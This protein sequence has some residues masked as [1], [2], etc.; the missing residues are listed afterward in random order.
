MTIAASPFFAFSHA[1]RRSLSFSPECSTSTGAL[2]R[3]RKRAIVCGVRP[4]S[5]TI[6]S[7]CLPWART[8]SSTLRYTSVLPEPVTPASNQAEKPSD[9]L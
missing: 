7:A 2:K 9:A 1:E 3:S 5:G 6:T 4:I 8:F